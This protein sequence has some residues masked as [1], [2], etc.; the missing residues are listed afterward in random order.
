MEITIVQGEIKYLEDCLEALMNSE[1]ASIYLPDE[2]VAR[3]H[4]IEA[5]KRKEMYLA[6]DREGKC[7]GYIRFVLNGM[8]YDFPYVCNIAVKE[9]FRRQGI[10]KRLLG[11]FEDI[12]FMHSDKVF[13]LVSGFNKQAKKLYESIG[14]KQ[15]GSID[16]LFKDGIL[17]YIM[18]K[19][20]SL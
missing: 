10:G 11:F 8:F 6:L 5:F 7:I 12:G 16:D 19:V 15:I 18:M 13:L 17:E 9:N 14:Y 1:L 4:L 20:K 2:N 3:N